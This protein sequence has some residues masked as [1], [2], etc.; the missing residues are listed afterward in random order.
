[1]KK[2]FII[3]I[4]VLGLYAVYR[5][6]TGANGSLAISSYSGPWKDGTHTGQP[7]THEYG[8]VQVAAVISG[9]K[10]S[11]VNFLQMPSDRSRSAEISS[12]SQP[13]L[14]QETIQSQNANVDI[15]SGATLTSQSYQQSLQSAL[16]QAK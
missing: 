5:L 14:L 9:G 7:Y 11:D 15:V 16:N 12:A 6:T 10:I 4:A 2:I 8:T 3:I 13:Q 1:M